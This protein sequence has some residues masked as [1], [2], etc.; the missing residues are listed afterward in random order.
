MACQLELLRLELAK[1]GG[2]SSEERVKAM[3]RERNDMLA[4]AKYSI[5]LAP[6]C[7]ALGGLAFVFPIAAV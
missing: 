1:R 7:L 6:A 3:R 5:F 4:K 2:P